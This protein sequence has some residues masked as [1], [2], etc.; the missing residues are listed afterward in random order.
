MSACVVTG[1]AGGIGRSVVDRLVEDGWSVVAV[2]QRAD[3]LEA[4]ARDRVTVLAGDVSDRGTHET[5]AATA[6][7]TGPLRGWVNCAG[8][9]VA[10]AAAEL[11]ELGL[12]RQL[13]VNLIGTIWGCSAA[14]AAMERG[15]IVSVSSIHAIRGFPGAF[16]YA[17]TKGAVDALTRQLAVEYGP[18]GIRANA[19]L[20]GAIATQMCFEDWAAAPDP[21]AARAGDEGLHLERRMGTP[22]EV[23]DVIAFLLSP[24][25]SLINGQCIAADGGAT[26]RPPYRPG[27]MD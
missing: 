8:V 1:A 18:R 12:R 25:S 3:R 9:Q 7:E 26:A 20:P 4:L 24:R 16:A 5:A 2:D 19:V 21:D 14:V 13:D 15:S 27:G 22:Q 10:A 23:A 11:D 6:R 17:A